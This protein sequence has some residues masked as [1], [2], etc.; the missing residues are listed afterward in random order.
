[1]CFQISQNLT[2]SSIASSIIENFYSNLFNVVHSNIIFPSHSSAN[3]ETII[4]IHDLMINSRY[5]FTETCIY[6]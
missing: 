4:N 2:E 6:L 5:I 1:M 3:E